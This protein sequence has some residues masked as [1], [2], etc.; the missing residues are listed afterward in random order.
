[1]KSYTAG[2]LQGRLSTTNNFGARA[3][4]NTRIVSGTNVTAENVRFTIAGGTSFTIEITWYEFN[5][6]NNGT[7]WSWFGD[8]GGY[9]DSA[10][11][12][13]TRFGPTV[14]NQSGTNNGVGFFSASGNAFWWNSRTF[15]VSQNISSIYFLVHCDRWDKVTITYS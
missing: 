7:T 9:L 8:W 1:M 2:G 5:I 14:K 12:W 4:S 6:F 10:N 15:G 11:N 13:S 3:I